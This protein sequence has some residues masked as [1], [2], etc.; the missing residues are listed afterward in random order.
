ML[1]KVINSALINPSV[2][3]GRTVGVGKISKANFVP[4]GILVHVVTVT[5][6][7]TV[8]GT[9]CDLMKFTLGDLPH[10]HG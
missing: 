3:I 9:T 6:S 7:C 4:A 1:W 5:V 8:R 2:N 10:Q